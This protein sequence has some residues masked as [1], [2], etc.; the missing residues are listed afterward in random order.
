MF[1]TFSIQMADFEC[2]DNSVLS[3]ASMS[4]S[5]ASFAH[6]IFRD[7][8]ETFPVE[9]SLVCKFTIQPSLCQQKCDRVGLYKVGWTSVDDHI[10]FVTVSVSDN[11]VTGMAAENC[12]QLDG[13]WLIYFVE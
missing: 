4:A 3:M 9:T 8:L 10:C 11:Y 13:W 5:H 6:V 12:V 7:V 1:F 2:I